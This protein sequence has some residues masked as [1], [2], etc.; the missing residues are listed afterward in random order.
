MCIAVLRKL[1]R[2]GSAKRNR[3]AQMCGISKPIGSRLPGIIQMAQ[4]HLPLSVLRMRF[5][6]AIPA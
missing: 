2:K 1:L 4:S 3:D 5:T 6:T